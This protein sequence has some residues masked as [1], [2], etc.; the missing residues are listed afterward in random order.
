MDIAVVGNGAVGSA[1]VEALGNAKVITRT[2]LGDVPK[3]DLYIIAVSDSAIDQVASKLPADALKVHTA[4][5]VTAEGVDGVIYPL[6]TFTKGRKVDMRRV[7]L[8]VEWSSQRAKD[9]IL[10][11]ASVLSDNVIYATSEQRIRA[12]VAAV[13]SCNFVNHL[14]ALSH[15]IIEDADLPD[16]I[17]HPL[18]EETIAK[19]LSVKNP[20]AVQ[21]GPAIRGDEAT[22]K[23]H[24]ELLDKSEREI[25][26]IISS[27]IMNYELRQL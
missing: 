23:R 17:L 27:S 2:M 18:I 9:A 25:Y 5:G 7:P 24:R 19:A 3:A 21:T 11:V 1:I 20:A 16:N 14:L 22:L 8:L 6:Q 13:F 12:H 26:D 4:G 15:R 10:E